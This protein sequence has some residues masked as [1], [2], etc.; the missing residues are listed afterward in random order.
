MLFFIFYLCEDAPV[1]DVRMMDQTLR[2]GET[3]LF[4]CQATGIP[5]PKIGWFFNGSPVEITNTKKYMISEL[6]FNPNTK[7]GTLKILDADSSDI[8]T[9]TCNATNKN[10]S[11]TSSARLAVNG[12]SCYLW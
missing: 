2:E 10:S 1:I 4:T 5:I 3:A 7:Y 8:G 12:K 9:Y 6:L 11:A